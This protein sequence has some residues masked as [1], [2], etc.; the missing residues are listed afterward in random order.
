[1]TRAVRLFEPKF[2]LLHVISTGDVGLPA[3]HMLCLEAEDGQERVITVPMILAAA[4]L[5]LRSDMLNL[6]S[7]YCLPGMR[8]ACVHLLQCWRQCWETCKL[9]TSV[10]VLWVLKGVAASIAFCTALHCTALLRPLERA[11]CASLPALAAV[12]VIGFR[13]CAGTI[14]YHE[15]E[16]ELSK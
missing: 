7:V 8:C 13:V 9:R 3:S 12:R 11:V 10:L 2:A 1:M 4:L 16:Q 15:F 6:V 14:Q 5:L